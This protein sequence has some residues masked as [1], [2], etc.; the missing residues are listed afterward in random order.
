MALD[1]ASANA[2]TFAV[3]FHLLSAAL[4]SPEFGRELHRIDEVIARAEQQA[5]ELGAS[6]GGQLGSRPAGG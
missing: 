1:A 6:T 3:A 4:P 2:G 5:A